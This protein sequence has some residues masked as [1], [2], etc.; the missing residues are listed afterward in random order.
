M[1]ILQIDYVFKIT[2]QKSAK[3][4]D[5]VRGTSTEINSYNSLKYNICWRKGINKTHC[6][7]EIQENQYKNY[8]EFI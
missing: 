2:S 8:H 6:P 5:D 1:S 3:T 7:L 4:F